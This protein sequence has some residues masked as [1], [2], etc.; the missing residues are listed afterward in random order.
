MSDNL[1]RDTLMFPPP[2]CYTIRQLIEFKDIDSLLKNAVKGNNE[3]VGM[4]LPVCKPKRITRPPFPSL[5]LS[6]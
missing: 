1:I 5:F 4:F 6:V 2:Q 3:G